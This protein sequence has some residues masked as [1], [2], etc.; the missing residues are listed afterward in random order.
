MDKKRVVKDSS[1]VRSG[2]CCRVDKVCMGTG[3]RLS[4]VSSFVVSD[5]PNVQTPNGDL[6]QVWG[7]RTRVLPDYPR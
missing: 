5:P 6:G 1:S 7:N 2:V 3:E 4:S